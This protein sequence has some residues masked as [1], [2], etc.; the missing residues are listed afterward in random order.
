MVGLQ[1]DL[2]QGTYLPRLQVILKKSLKKFQWGWIEGKISKAYFLYNA[3]K[4]IF[5]PN[6][7]QT[8]GQ[9]SILKRI[10]GVYCVVCRGADFSA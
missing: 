1:A 10:V 3:H 2:R 7:A 9:K 4:F 5:S 6:S 8:S